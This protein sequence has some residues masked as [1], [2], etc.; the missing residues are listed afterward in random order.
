MTPETAKKLA[1]ALRQGLAD[2]GKP[3]EKKVDEAVSKRAVRLI[4]QELDTGRSRMSEVPRKVR[5]AS[6]ASLPDKV[7]VWRSVALHSENPEI[8]PE[9]GVVSTTRN[10][11]VAMNMATN[12]PVLMGKDKFIAPKPAILR[13]EV[14]RDR[15]HAY[16]PGMIDQARAEHGDELKKMK[17]TG[18]RSYQRMSVHDVF[19]Q[20]HRE[21]E[22]LA[23]V[24]GL[25]P[26]VLHFHGGEQVADQEHMHA[27]H[28][29]VQGRAQG[30]GAEYI[31]DRKKYG[32][33]FRDEPKAAQEYD[34]FFKKARHHFREDVNESED[35]NQLS[36]KKNDYDGFHEY[37]IHH[38]KHGHIGLLS[39][40][41]K[42]GH[43]DVTSVFLHPEYLQKRGIEPHEGYG[44]WWTSAD[45][46]R[47]HE[48]SRN[49]LGVS[50][51]R[52]ITQELRRHGVKSIGSSERNTG[53]RLHS[54]AREHGVPQNRIKGFDVKTRRLESADQL[55]RATL[56]EIAKPAKVK[57][58]AMGPSPE[59]PESLRSMDFYHGVDNDEAAH[60][61]LASGRL[62]PATYGHNTFHKGYSSPRP[63]KVYLTGDHKHAARIAL[64][65]TTLGDDSEQPDLNQG[66]YGYVFRVAGR[67]LN[68]VEADEDNIERTYWNTHGG[69][70]AGLGVHRGLVDLGKSVLSQKDHETLL[71]AG[72]FGR[73]VRV[74]K[75]LA[76]HLTPD[77]H[78]DLIL[79]Q[80]AH[81]AH[82]GPI[83]IV[84]A[85]RI[86]KTRN[87]EFHWDGSDL[88]Q[89]AEPLHHLIGKGLK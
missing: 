15:V 26:E 76:S 66:R 80:G 12:Y 52:K 24:S 27:I 5:D 82:G 44:N 30:T 25:T 69:G 22:V 41:F 13:Y 2:R 59:V 71:G 55:I 7:T 35:P 57:F 79:S 39:G 16:V 4:A 64:S 58:S 65:G 3:V 56:S 6:R 29:L 61:I 32:T 17:I 33:Y 63:D 46:A 88:F 77:V 84:G 18:R 83:K 48:I 42:D 34:D 23:D 50:G 74:A 72:S 85:W 81:V 89:K 62:E 75:K 10:P 67:D 31:A 14:P 40:H 78:H 60:K 37:E 45:M 68:N 53:T 87:D 43:L 49:L 11:R 86:D 51:V 20:T 28:D 19:D 8:R 38:Q 47:D 9:T 1:A 21:D 70:P 54:Y 36:L 73:R